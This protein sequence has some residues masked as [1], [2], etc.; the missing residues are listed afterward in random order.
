MFLA[1]KRRGPLLFGQRMSMDE[2]WVVTECDEGAVAR[3]ASDADVSPVLA[4]L[5]INRGLTTATAVR[6]FLAP[7]LDALHDPFLLPDMQ[8]AVDR[9]A[10]AVLNGELICIHGD[11]DVDGVTGAALLVRTLRA[12]GAN[13]AYRLPHRRREGYDIKAATVEELAGNGVRLIVTCDCGINAVEA[14]EKANEL[15][16]DVIV[17]DHHEPGAD[18]PRAVAVV[19]PKRRDASYPF[20]ELAGVGVAYKLAQALVIKLD[21]NEESFKAKFVDLVTLGT[22]A[23]VVP[24]VGENRVF[25]KHGLESFATSRKTGI[26]SMLNLVNTSGKPLSTFMLSYVLAPRINAVGRMDDATKALELLLT[27]DEAE[28]AAL[29]AEMER[30]N[31]DRKAEQER[32]LREAVEQVEAKDLE[33]C[34]VLVLSAEGWNTGVVGIAA[35][36][37]CEQYARPTIL[38]CRDESCGMGFGS[39]RSTECFDI[40]EALRQCDGLLH[41]YGGHCAAAGLSVDL[42]NLEAFE[43]AVNDYAAETLEP[44]ELVPRIVLDAELS[45][46]DISRQLADSLVQMEPFG[47]GNPEPLFLSRDMKVLDRQRVGD[48]SHLRLRVSGNGSGSLSCIGFGLGGLE[49]SLEL[50]S[51]VDMCYAIRL[52]TYNGVES[53]QLVVKAIR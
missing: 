13:V 36:K 9:L 24:L 8:S 15:G 38:L 37:I 49:D 10:A 25:V 17:S 18:L 16:V 7:S 22:V 35:G 28:A 42:A 32:I 33:S 3:L 45:A 2:L 5:F 46:G 21:S 52:N 23:D 41:R 4:R 27:Q 26:Q 31:T 19:N 34:P 11:Y 50:G 1:G 39:A 43:L 51:S 40:L 47:V 6:E 53:V 29:V 30:H 48:G 12:L 44:E 20:P 14:V